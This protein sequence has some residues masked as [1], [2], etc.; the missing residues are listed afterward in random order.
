MRQQLLLFLIAGS[1]YGSFTAGAFA[2]APPSTP[3][4]PSGHGEHAYTLSISL[5]FLGVYK[6]EKEGRKISYI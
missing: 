1:L 5:N 3:V 4:L 6:N 2:N